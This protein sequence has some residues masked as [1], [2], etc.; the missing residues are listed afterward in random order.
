[1][2]P[3]GELLGLVDAL[4]VSDVTIESRPVQRPLAPWLDQGAQGDQVAREIRERLEAELDGGE[5]TGFS[6]RIVD[7]EIWFVQTFASV[8]AVAA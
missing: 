5:V 2:F 6:P 7:G 8:V 4:D 3:A 1:M